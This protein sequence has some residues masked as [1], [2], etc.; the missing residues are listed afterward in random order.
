M[1]R[2]LDQVTIRDRKG[3]EL[4]RYA[5]CYCAL[6]GTI[7]NTN[8]EAYTFNDQED[9]PQAIVNRYNEALE[10]ASQDDINTLW[11]MAC[12]GEWGVLP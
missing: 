11:A 6:A 12:G 9:V 7:D 1:T 10:N 5:D 2:V 8:I 4:D 3:N